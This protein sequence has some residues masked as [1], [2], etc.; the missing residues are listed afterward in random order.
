M[1]G[2][3]HLFKRQLQ[4]LGEVSIQSFAVELYVFEDC[5]QGRTFR[6]RSAP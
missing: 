1:D 2:S 3:A 6:N 5:F 4:F